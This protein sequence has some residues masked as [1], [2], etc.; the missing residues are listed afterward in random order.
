MAE[1]GGS[2][3][4][5]PRRLKGFRDYLPI[6]MAARW[7]IIDKIRHEAR[8]AG[9][10]MIGTPAL[11]YAEILLGQGG[12]ETDKQSYRFKD[13]G[14]RDVA[15]RFD[16]TVP[17]ARFVAEHQNELA[18]PFKKLQMGDVWRGENT[19][20]GRY[21]EFMQCDLD[22]I[23]VDSAGADIEILNTFQKILSRIDP[24]AFT[25]SIGHRQILTAMIRRALPGIGPAG[26]TSALV[27]IDKLAKIG[28][29]K[30]KSLLEAIPGAVSGGAAADDLLAAL[31]AKNE[32]GDTDLTDVESFL[33]R[34]AEGAR[35][36]LDRL[37]EIMHTVRGLAML[38]KGRFA[39]DLAIARGLGYYT[40]IVFET[41]LDDLEGFGSISSGGRYNDLASRFTTREL[42]GVGGSVGLDRL[43]AGLE[44]LGRLQTSN[45]ALVFVAVA[46]EDARAYAF[47]IADE[48]RRAGMVVDVGLVPKLSNQFK[49]ADKLG[50]SHV[51]TVG[52]DERGKRTY[53]LKTLKTGQ[54]QRDLPVGEIVSTLKS[55]VAEPPAP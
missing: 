12:E 32:I 21:R 27:A 1:G 24:G 48:L 20:K 11:E 15:L 29:E 19:Q 39:V 26:E 35:A 23:G 30:V 4:V 14:D 36:H 7:E 34:S 46:S 13:H 37:R 18:F 51:V 5:E 8:L 9:F 52:G 47:Q 42:P 3:R 49:H 50:A 16:L 44:E 43:I 45:G 10:Q 33:G 55:R 28:P 17:F 22:I 2:K 25:I 41:T 31:A 6:P 38:G 40:G 54:E 53:A